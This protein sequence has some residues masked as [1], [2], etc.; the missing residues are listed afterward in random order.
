MELLHD[1]APDVETFAAFV[2]RIEPGLRRSLVATYGPVDG[3]EA[4]V[5][6]LSWAWEHWDR[7]SAINNE[8][9]YL[10][11]VGQSS[12]RRFAAT[13]VAPKFPQAITDELRDIE[14]GLLPALESLSPQQRAV[15]LLVH[16]HGWSQAEVGRMLGINPSTVREH[17]NRAMTRLRDQLEVN[18]AN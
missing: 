1:H 17:L 13:A 18:D 16:A 9:A 8:S 12:V 5:E 7:L 15:V 4:T 11:R 14:P 3:R 6:A 10:Y 2:D